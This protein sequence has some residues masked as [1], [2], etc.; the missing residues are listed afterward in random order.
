MN[1]SFIQFIRI[2]IIASIGGFLMSF[3]S[4]LISDY[5]TVFDLETGSF[6]LNFSTS[7]IIY[8]T[9]IGCL[10]AGILSDIIG[11]KS[12]LQ[13]SALLFT[14]SGF[15]CTAPNISFFIIGQIIGGLGIGFAFLV[16]PL[17][18]AEIAPTKQRG[19]LVLFFPLL[20]IIGF[21]VAHFSNHYILK[22]FTD[23]KLNWRLMHVIEIISAIIY[24]IVLKFIPE[25]PRWLLM[26]GYEDKSLSVLSK[27]GN[28]EYLESAYSEI[29][30]SLHAQSEMSI[31]HQI[32][33]LFSKQMS[34]VITI[35]IGLS[36]LQRFSGINAMLYNV[37]SF[38]GSNGNENNSEFLQKII[39]E[40][41]FLLATILTMFLI[42]RLGRK[43]LSY[44]GISLM[45]LSLIFTGI[46]YK[47]ASYQLSEQQLNEVV[48]SQ[49]IIFT[50]N[51]LNLPEMEFENETSF[52]TALDLAVVD[53]PTKTS[54][55]K[56]EFL[57]KAI[58]INSFGIFISIL[59]FIVGFSISLGTVTWVIFSEIFPYKIRG[60]AIS[61]L[62]T[63]NVIS[64]YF[65]TLILPIQISKY[66][67][68]NT[69]FI[70]AGLMLFGLWFT[71]QYIIETKGK[72]LLQ[73][74]NEL[75][76]NDF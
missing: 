2:S 39:F 37:P 76:T 7:S 35:G 46:L 20:I 63:V 57:K 70:Y 22:T 3:N 66:G 32:R 49:K 48:K 38:L 33:T 56:A 50:Q 4:A 52:T 8:G 31:F 60:L 59:V 29:K 13:I 19:F 36:I 47:R 28:T 64:G 72:S 15:F 73:L 68:A 23:Q 69:Y 54:S 40:F 51:L 18:I 9:I 34:L 6:L 1:I 65:A 75:K 62:G 41:V 16:I 67:S 74:E 25:S 44:I 27:L 42:D 71:W 53:F 17:Y 30:N 61:I 12:M 5:K 26:K 10:F 21:L 24:F 43:P 45:T 14:F 11:R 58:K 55:I